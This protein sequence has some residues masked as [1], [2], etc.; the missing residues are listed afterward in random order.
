MSNRMPAWLNRQIEADPE[1]FVPYAGHVEPQIVQLLDGSYLAASVLHG[2][3]FELAPIDL[4]NARVQRINTLLRS[5]ADI[6]LTVCFHLVRHERVSDA[7]QPIAEGGF[8]RNLMANYRTTALSNVFCNSWFITVVVSP[9][10]SPKWKLSHWLP[11]RGAGVPAASRKRRQRLLDVMQMIDSTLSEYNPRRLGLYD[12]PTDIP[13]QTIPIT[14]IGS[15]LHM[16]RTG[17]AQPIPHTTGPLY[18]AVYSSPVVV[19]AKS[20]DLNLPGVERRGAMIGLLNYPLKPRPGMFNSLLSAPYSLVL[21]NIYR[22]KSASSAVSSMALIKQ[23]MENSGDAA[24]DLA[25]G[26]RVA[27]N[28]TASLQTS[29]GSHH[30]GLA[31]YGQDDVALDSN[32]ADASQRISRFGGAVPIRETNVWYNGALETAYYLQLPGCPVFQPRPGT[33]STLDLACM[34]SLDNY[35]LG[36]REGYW[37]KSP[38]RLKTNGLTVYDL[39]THDEDVGHAL[40]IGSN[41][42][43]KTVLLGLIC[44]AMEPVMGAEGIRLVIDKDNANRLMVEASGG[45]YRSLL[46]N[47]ASGLAPLVAFSDTPRS[48]AFFHSLYTWLIMR[49]GRGGL[50]NDE[51]GRL[52]RGIARQ[53]LMP[54]HLRSMGGVRELLG[55]G[56]RDNG[57]G[58]RFERWCEGGSMGWLL[59]NKT[60]VISMGAGLYGFDFTELIPKEGQAD[61]GAC[62]AAAAVIMHQLAELMDGRRIAAFFDECRFYMEP[63]RRM[64]EDYTLTG[65]KKELM[66]WLIAQ[67]PEHFTDTTMGMALVQ[68]MRTKFIFPDASLDPENL[69]K[70]K[71]SPAAIRMLRTDM[72]LGDARRFLLWRPDAPAICEFDLSGLP[73]LPILSGRS[74]TIR[75]MERIR[76]ESGGSNEDV[77]EEFL[78][79][80]ANTKR[81][82]A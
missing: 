26:L 33:I 55:Y 71:L 79:R 52:M 11:K 10:T 7:P 44:A 41:G 48:R 29:S 61:D 66:C 18:S 6:D 56:D 36:N 40:V 22:F 8:V 60:H 24:E 47:V 65:R 17:V 28:A 59:D 80:H 37:G 39:I 16:I 45:T 23:Q 72:T 1:R 25:K 68:Q 42:K 69:A 70:L 30:F 21:S 4:R 75:L 58:A 49:D 46:R 20:F 73:Q 14:E 2:L 81:I 15:A 27:M 76:Q 34:A 62:T 53:L 13:G 19:D 57:V 77:V 74:G 43:G 63:L 12:S 31:V 50:K 35:P 32:V 3:P 78:I 51:D 5:L 54:P 82:A 67:Q 64:I 38:I 9:E